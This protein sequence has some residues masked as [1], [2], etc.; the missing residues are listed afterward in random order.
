MNRDD[1]N[2]ESLTNNWKFRGSSEED[3]EENEE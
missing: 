2:D 1:N 3:E